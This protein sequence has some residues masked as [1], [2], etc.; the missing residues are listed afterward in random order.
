MT[1]SPQLLASYFTIAGNVV[2]LAGNMTSPHSLQE[3]VTA[4]TDAGFIGIGLVTDDLDRLVAE[5]GYEGIRGIVSDAGLQHIELEVLLDWFADG[6]R[7]AA[8]DIIRVKLLR[9]AERLGAFQIK[10][11]GDITRT[12]WPLDRMI[13]SFGEL[14]RQAGDA[15]TTVSLEIFPDSNVRDLPTAIAIAKGADPR[16]GGLL[17]DVWHFYRGDIPYADIGTIPPEYIKHI[18]IDDAAVARVGSVIEDTLLRRKLPGEGDSDVPA[19]LAA[20]AATGY[21]GL[22][23]VEILSDEIRKLSPAEAARRSFQATMRQFE[24]LAVTR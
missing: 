12:E 14:A 23:G 22:Y 18:E 6:E 1:P 5:H 3:R 17:L 10:I 8:S 11:G 4:A 24:R 20:V 13:E 15:G 21:Q 2:P 9:A 19:F 7:R 16:F